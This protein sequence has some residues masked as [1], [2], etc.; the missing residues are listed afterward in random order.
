MAKAAHWWII[1][2]LII[3]FAMTACTRSPEAQKARHLERG[4]KYFAREQD[5]EA[6]IEYRNVLRLE[7]AHVQ[8]VRQLGLAYFRLGELGPAASYLQKSQQLDPANLDVRQK[9]GTL[10]LLGG[11]PAEALQEAAFILGKDANNLDALAL[12][13]GAARTPQEITTATEQLKAAQP[14]L[15]DYAKLYLALGS[16]YLRK[17]NLVEAENTFKEAIAKEPR[18]VD[19]HLALGTF[20]EAK[21]DVVSAERELKAAVD[22]APA[23]SLSSFTLANFYLREGKSTAGKQLLG[24]ITKKAPGF[25]PAWHRI[26]EVSLAEGRFDDTAKA[27]EVILK[28]N[29]SDLNALLLRGRMRLAKSETAEAIQDFQQILKLEGRVAA[30]HYQLALAHLQAGNTQQARAELNEAT[31]VDPNFT[32]ASL[33]GAELDIRTGAVAPAI[34]ALQRTTA[35]RPSEVRAYVLL[36]LAYLSSREPIKAMETYRKIVELAPQD[37]RGPYLVGVSLLAQGKRVEAQREFETSLAMAPAFAEPLA[38]LVSVA[39]A[40]KKLDVAFQR[41]QRQIKLV[42]NSGELQVLLGETHRVRGDLTHAETAYLKALE[43]QP[44]L[45]EPYL[46]LAELYTQ[47]GNDEQALAKLEGALRANPQSLPALMLSGNIYERRGDFSRA[48]EAY[49]KVLAVNPRFGPAANNLAY[50]LTAHGGDKEKALQLA[51]TAK[52]IAP[53]EPHVSDTL[54]WILY[55][56]GVYQRAFALLKE[57]AAKLPENPEIQ[58][59]LGMAAL[60]AGDTEIA[61]RSL[62]KATA[63]PT[64]FAGKEEAQKTLTQLK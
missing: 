45:F 4:D 7:P 62:A 56:R 43:L 9:L 30:V 15:A 42:P 46:K 3:L 12:F 61:R 28:K 22:L 60:K 49:E 21:R 27:V 51:Q 36:G 31:N 16:L 6:I 35:N 41:V 14:S 29:P 8:A 40:E 17:Q 10:Y 48:Q 1:P 47:T 2:L 32:E 58:Y 34:E 53:D 33:L 44:R 57:S 55:N 23:G 13:A 37:P 63:A 25:L 52:Q 11:R 19:A 64:H 54:G 26:A 38:Q 24:E 18:S 50:L 20:Y 39:W 59:H 5:R